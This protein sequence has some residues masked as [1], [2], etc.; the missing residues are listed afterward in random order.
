MIELAKLNAA[1]N[2]GRSTLTIGLVAA[3][4][5]L[6]LAISAFHLET[7]DAGTGG[8]DY[9]ATS[10]QSIHYDVNTDAGRIE[11]GFSDSASDELADWK[12]Y[13]MRVSDGEDASCL[14]LYR[15]TQ[16]RVL[17]V[18]IEFVKRGG[19]QWSA[20]A[21]AKRSDPANDVRA[22]AGVVDDENPW[23]NFGDGRCHGGVQ[24]ALE[25]R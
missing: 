16:P 19:F 24:L 20:V 23:R 15:P 3:A 5:F 25:R 7:S 11:L 14:N 9:L 4:S 1:R 12:V 21:H 2:P 18:P 22:A 13:S 6:I 10:V 17:G 8:F